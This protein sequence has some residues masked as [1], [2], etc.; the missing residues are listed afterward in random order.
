MELGRVGFKERDISDLLLLYGIEDVVEHERLLTLTRAANAPG[1]WYPY[2]DLLPISFRTYLGLEEAATL[3]RIYEVQFVP[4]LL[5]TAAY[6]RAVARLGQ[7]Q[8]DASV[9]DRWVELH[10]IR[11]QLLDRPD[12]PPVWAVLDEAVLRRSRSC[13]SP[14]TSCPTPSTSNSSPAPSLS[15]SIRTSTGTSPRCR[16]CSSRPLHPSRPRTSCETC[17]ATSTAMAEIHHSSLHQ[18]FRATPQ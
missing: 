13:G 15:T 6:A 16:A 17:Y 18:P 14:L 4:G 8:A 12:A 1:W 2:N 11:T 7:G 3:V 9:L 10:T 5:Q